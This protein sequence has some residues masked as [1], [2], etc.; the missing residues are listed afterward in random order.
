MDAVLENSLISHRQLSVI[1]RIHSVAA[2]TASPRIPRVVAM[3]SGAVS[4]VTHQPQQLLLFQLS[5]EMSLGPVLNSNGFP[6]N[7]VGRVAAS[8]AVPTTASLDMETATASGAR[9]A[10]SEAAMKTVPTLPETSTQ[11]GRL[12]ALLGTEG[13]LRGGDGIER[14]RANR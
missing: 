6:V 4:G 1:I 5:G 7:S 11:R 13:R 14:S 12:N 10:T 2:Q 3:A 9:T 8:S